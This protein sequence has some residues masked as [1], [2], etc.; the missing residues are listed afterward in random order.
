MPRGAPRLRTTDDALNQIST[1]LQ[2]RR[3]ELGLTQDALCARLAQASEGGWIA[4]RRDIFRLEHGR[5]IVSDL[6]LLALAL[7]LECDACW[8]LL[9]EPKS[10]VRF[11]SLEP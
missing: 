8:L 11:K 9:G 4:D 7:A 5:R 10:T 6:E 1:R 2:E 3:Q